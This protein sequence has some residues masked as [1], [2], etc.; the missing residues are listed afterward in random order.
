MRQLEELSLWRTG[1]TGNVACFAKLKELRECYLGGCIGI[2]G[3]AAAAFGALALLRVLDV[4]GTQ[5]SGAISTRGGELKV[6]A[7]DAPSVVVG[8]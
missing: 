6:W 5:C 2:K 7:A 1:T 8:S 4:A 3:D